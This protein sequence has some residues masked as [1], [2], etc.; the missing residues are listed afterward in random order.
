MRCV[1]DSKVLWHG[2]LV[3][4]GNIRE[5][6]FLIKLFTL[7]YQESALIVCSEQF[8]IVDH[9]HKLFLFLLFDWPQAN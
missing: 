8:K 9:V 2:N 6:Q 4:V 1:T 7:L 5:V 3:K